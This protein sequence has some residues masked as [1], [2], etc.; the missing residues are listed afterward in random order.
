MEVGTLI[1]RKLGRGKR[2]REPYDIFLNGFLMVNCH[3]FRALLKG[4]KL[5]GNWGNLSFL[6][7]MF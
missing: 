3:G 2:I 5:L 4:L 6:K 7:R 1:L